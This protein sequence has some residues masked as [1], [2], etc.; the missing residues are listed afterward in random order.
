M[1]MATHPYGA[2]NISHCESLIHSP[3]TIDTSSQVLIVA[4]GRSGSSF[5]G[6]IFNSNPDIFFIFEPFESIKI[7][8]SIVTLRIIF[9]ESDM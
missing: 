8:S 5:L 7:K 6:G 4:F 3:T 2:E 9:I 1:E